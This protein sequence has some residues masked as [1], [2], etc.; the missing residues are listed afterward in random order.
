MKGPIHMAHAEVFSDGAVFYVAEGTDVAGRRFTGIYEAKCYGKRRPDSDGH[1]DH[2]ALIDAAFHDKTCWRLRTLE[3]WDEDE[4]YANYDADARL[5]RIYE[6]IGPKN[7]WDPSGARKT[8][9]S[10][11]IS[12]LAADIREALDRCSL[13]IS[14]DAA[15]LWITQAVIEQLIA[16]GWHR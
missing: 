4:L 12:A 3:T 8:Q 6:W 13:W 16:K 2:Q 11:E 5:V 9:T 14:D 7:D 15:K 10:A 1:D